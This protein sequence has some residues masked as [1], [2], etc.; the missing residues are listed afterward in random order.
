MPAGV[1]KLLTTS[2][3]V[4]SIKDEIAAQR[5]SYDN[6]WAFRKDVYV[7]LIKLVSDLV[8]LRLGFLQLANLQ[9]A[10]APTDGV[11]LQAVHEQK[12]ANLRRYRAV[13][14]QYI[15]QVAI[16]PLAMADNVIVALKLPQP[17]LI[18]STQPD[19]IEEQ[20]IRQEV[21]A[22]NDILRTLAEGGRKDLWG[23]PEPQAKA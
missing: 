9:R 10:L 21:S 14:K 17:T 18:G 7:N 15:N 23:A 8:H 11:E 1:S 5:R 20:Q 12:A 2:G 22:L 13:L 6:R 19:P 4:E 3:T 16:A